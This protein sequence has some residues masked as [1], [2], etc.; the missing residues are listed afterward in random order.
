M[1]KDVTTPNK[2][3]PIKLF[4]K[5]KENIDRQFSVVYPFRTVYPETQRNKLAKEIQLKERK[6]LEEGTMGI[7]ESAEDVQLLARTMARLK[8]GVDHTLFH[9]LGASIHTALTR[10]NSTA[11]FYDVRAIRDDVSGKRA[12]TSITVSLE[13][14]VKLALGPLVNDNGRSITGA[15]PVVKEPKKKLAELLFKKREPFAAASFNI[16]KD[17][18]IFKGVVHGRPIIIDQ[19]SPTT[20]AFTILLDNTFFPVAE[21]ETDLKM[22][23]L[24]LHHVAGLSSVIALGRYILRQANKGSFPQTP[25]VHKTLL[26][27]QAAAEM[28]MFAPGIIRRQKDGRYNFVFR[29]ASAVKELRPSAIRED[30]YIRYPEVSSFVG[31]VGSIYATALREL[32]IL[33]HLHPN[34][35]VPAIERGAEFP[36]HI[37]KEILYIKANTV[38]ASFKYLK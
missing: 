27:F 15:G 13:G 7:V 34:T 9:D 19:V 4:D 3:Q 14:L 33:Q 11:T 37:S 30:G 2:E 26:F 35:L 18:E 1:K 28:Q 5:S 22:K 6:F 31:Q 20:K 17:G 32:D 38:E 23:E 16:K 8:Y 29:R 24:H 10:P 21:N 36:D 12:K 25:E